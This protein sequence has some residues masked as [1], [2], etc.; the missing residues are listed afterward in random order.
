MAVSSN[1]TLPMLS[2]GAAALFTSAT[3]VLQACCSVMLDLTTYASSCPADY[4]QM[5]QL[6]QF[7]S[8]NVDVERELTH[9][10]NVPPKHIAT[11]HDGLSL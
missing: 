11:A 7:A 5:Q 2:S 10:F 9:A 1:P 4:R 6:V 8:G 3:L